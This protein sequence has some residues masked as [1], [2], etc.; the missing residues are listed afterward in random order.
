MIGI[1]YKYNHENAD[2]RSEGNI[3]LFIVTKRI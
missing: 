1:K 3:E 2:H